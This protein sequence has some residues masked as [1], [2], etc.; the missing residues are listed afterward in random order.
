[1]AALQIG[2]NKK[3]GGSLQET[4]RFDTEYGQ[5]SSENLKIS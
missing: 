5:R 4:A 2:C 1:M 3:W